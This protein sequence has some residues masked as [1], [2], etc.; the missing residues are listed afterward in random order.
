MF[1]VS[2][3]EGSAGVVFAFR[4]CSLDPARSF[5][6]CCILLSEISPSV[7]HSVRVHHVKLS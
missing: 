3:S 6:I 2:V 4:H 1:T 5:L 7:A